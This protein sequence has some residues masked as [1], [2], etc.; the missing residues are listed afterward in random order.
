MPGNFLDLCLLLLI[1][2]AVSAIP[3]ISDGLSEICVTVLCQSAK[4]NF[5]FG[6]GGSPAVVW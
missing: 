1:L 3:S 5:S 2:W 6:R 4:F